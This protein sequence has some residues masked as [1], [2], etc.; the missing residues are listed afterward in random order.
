MVALA[1]RG[2]FGS[3]VPEDAYGGECLWG[4]DGRIWVE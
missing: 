4:K 3:C 2:F 1:N